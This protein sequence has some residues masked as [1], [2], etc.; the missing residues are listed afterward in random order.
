VIGTIRREC[1]DHVII[2][3]VR[4][5]KRVLAEY[6]AYSNESRTHLA[7]EKDCPGSRLVENPHAGEIVALPV[8][9]GL[10]RRYTRRSGS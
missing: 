8:L 9:D 5:L 1:L 2:F 7:I 4:H 10:H 3:N 6:L